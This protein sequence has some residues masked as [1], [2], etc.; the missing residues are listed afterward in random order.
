MVITKESLKTIITLIK[1][2]EPPSK[3]LK[4]TEFSQKWRDEFLWLRT[5]TS[6]QGVIMFYTVCVRD[7]AN[8]AYTRGCKTYQHNF[9]TRHKSLP[10]HVNAMS[11]VKLSENIGGKT[12]V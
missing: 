12:N 9:L 4:N 5:E 1:T 3:K 6:D 11:N 8:N 2:S 7:R 10:D